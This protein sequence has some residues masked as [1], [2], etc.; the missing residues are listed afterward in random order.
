MALDRDF[1]QD[2][3]RHTAPAAAPGSLFET[4]AERVLRRADAVIAGR[5][6]SWPPTTQQVHFLQL[7]RGHQGKRRIVALGD[8]AERLH[9]TPRAVKELVQELRLNFGVQI[10]ASREG[11]SGGYYLISTYDESVEST[12][13]MLRQ[14]VT[15]LKVVNAMRGGRNHIDQMLTQIRLDL[16]Q[17]AS[18]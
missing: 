11:E 10:G 5:E 4:F 18:R 17:E 15:M 7:L 3:Y 1:E 14:A 6:C 13:P 16:T 9:L 8:F 12:E 2:I